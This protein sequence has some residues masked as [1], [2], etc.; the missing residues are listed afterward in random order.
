MAYALSKQSAL[1]RDLTPWSVNSKTLD[2]N[3]I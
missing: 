3:Q 2:N 1:I